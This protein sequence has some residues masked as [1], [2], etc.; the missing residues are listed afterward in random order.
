MQCTCTL[1]VLV[2]SSKKQIPVL[3][4]ARTAGAPQ[5]LPQELHFPLGAHGTELQW[6]SAPPMS[7]CHADL[8]CGWPTC[9]S[10]GGGV[11]RDSLVRDE[12]AGGGV[13]VARVPQLGIGA[14][15]GVDGHTG[16]YY[17]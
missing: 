17:L 10:H 7:Q 8:K 5:G 11:V 9:H 15:R 16:G 1:L 14:L 4:R 6:L 2:G 12:P 3:A 13:A